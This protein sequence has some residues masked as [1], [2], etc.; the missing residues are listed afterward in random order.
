MSRNFCCSTMTFTPDR[1]VFDCWEPIVSGVEVDDF[2]YYP[3]SLCKGDCYLR[4]ENL[5]EYSVATTKLYTV[6]LGFRGYRDDTLNFLILLGEFASSISLFI[7]VNNV[8][9]ISDT[10]ITIAFSLSWEKISTSYRVLGE[11]KLVKLCCPTLTQKPIIKRGSLY[12]WK[13]LFQLWQ[14]IDWSPW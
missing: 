1:D 9:W 14:S 11:Q 2:V 3:W 12:K 10:W 6:G 4:D 8:L 5:L 13:P 7:N